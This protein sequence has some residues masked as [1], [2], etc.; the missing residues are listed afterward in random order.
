MNETLRKRAKLV[1]VTNLNEA[2]RISLPK[3][4]PRHVPAREMRYCVQFE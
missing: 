2:Y 1:S 4:N 3:G